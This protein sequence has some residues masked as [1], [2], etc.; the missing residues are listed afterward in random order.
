MSYPQWPK[1]EVRSGAAVVDADASR[2]K[3]EA[4]F[5]GLFGHPTLLVPSG[6]AAISLALRAHG[7]NRSQ[8]LI[9]PR[10][11]SHC[12]WD[13]VSHYA[14]PS[15]AFDSSADVALVVHKWGHQHGLPAGFTG[16]VIE[17]SVDSLIAGPGGLFPSGGSFEVISLPKVLGTFSGGLLVCRSEAEWEKALT[18]RASDEALSLRQDELKLACVRD[19]GRIREWYPYDWENFQLGPNGLAD[20]V[21]ALKTYPHL[22]ESVRQRHRRALKS[23]LRSRVLSNPKQHPDRFPTV[24]P[25]RTTGKTLLPEYHFA[26]DF[27][28][29]GGAYQ[30]V[31]GLP[32]HHGVSESAFEA[33]LHS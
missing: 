30:K 3:V 2:Q 10:W 20:V 16:V 15:A 19:E 28:G 32:L 33:A 9:A 25:L 23:H 22:L 5:T 14:N 24:L 6:R 8:L 26:V 4:F 27:Q 31:Q 7:V 13:T 18:A 21:E 17:D 29:V 12:V 1:P 11:S